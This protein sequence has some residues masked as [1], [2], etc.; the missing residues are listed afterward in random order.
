MAASSAKKMP[1]VEAFCSAQDSLEEGVWLER[2]NKLVAEVPGEEIDTRSGLSHVLPQRSAHQ[3]WQSSGS[4][5][6]CSA[7]NLRDSLAANCS[8]RNLFLSGFLSYQSII[9]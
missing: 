7:R 3:S 1:T 8:K 2:A 9:T 5:S 4:G 6:T